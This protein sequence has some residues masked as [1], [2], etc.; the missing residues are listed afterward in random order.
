MKHKIFFMSLVSLFVI[1]CSNPCENTICLNGGVCLDGTCD[2]PDGFTGNDCS[3]I[4]PE[5]ND[6]VFSPCDEQES[7]TYHGKEYSIVEIGTDCWFAE[8]LKT[9][10]FSNGDD[11]LNKGPIYNNG[12]VQYEE[13]VYFDRLY[14]DFNLGYLYNGYVIMDERNVCPQ[15]WH[16]S[17]DSDW[18]NLEFYAGLDEEQLFW[19]YDEGESRG[20]NIGDKLKSSPNDNPSWNGTNDFGLSITRNNE[21]S[22]ESS[23][24]DNSQYWTTDLYPGL[25][26]YYVG[27]GFK[28][29][30][31]SPIIR[32]IL[33]VKGPGGIRCVKD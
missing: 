7:I 12:W 11:I 5:I 21:S 22:N 1:S 6:D 9:E 25:E 20:I 14:T 3:T 28:N 19:G 16:V 18:F 8:D 26:T 27:R 13:P 24:W 10:K 17:T 29:Y 15:G 2:C 33:D 30:E 23:S 31:N 4:V 32:G